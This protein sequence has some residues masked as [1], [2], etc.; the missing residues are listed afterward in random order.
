MKVKELIDKL[1]DC[2]QEKEVIIIYDFGYGK[3]TCEVVEEHEEK[4]II[5]ES[6]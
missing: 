6:Y 2:N 1:K 4:V 3:A 5:T